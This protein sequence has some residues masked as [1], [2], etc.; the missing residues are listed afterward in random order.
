[1]LNEALKICVDHI[2]GIRNDPI[3]PQISY[4]ELSAI[5]PN[6]PPFEGKEIQEVINDV[7]DTILPYATKIGHPRFLAWII[8]SPSPAGTIGEMINTGL[9]QVPA[10]FKGGK[11]STI[12]EETV[13]RWFG[14][15]FGYDENHGGILVSGGTMANLTAMAAA[16]EAKYPGAMKTGIQN[17]E[18]PLT[19]Y[20]S[21][22]SHISVDRS[23]GML[24]IGADMVRK[25]STDDDYKMRLDLLEEAVFNDRSSGFEP[26]CV[27]AQAGAVNTGSIDPIDELADFCSKNGLWYHVDASY[28]GGAVLAENGKELLK[29]I[30]K[31]D[32]IATDPHKWFFIPVE[33]GLTLVKNRKHLFNAFN[34]KASY[35]G[36]ETAVDYKDYG[37]QLTRASRALK[38]WFS[39]RVYGL[40][41]LG[42][43]VNRNIY[44]AQKLH[45]MLDKE[46]CWEVL[47]PTE[48]SIVC[49]R[50]IPGNDIDEESLNSLQYEILSEVEKSGK[51]FITPAILRGKTALRICFANHRTTSEDV[52]IL[53]KIILDIGE[54]LSNR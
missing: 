51:A 54:K 30:E 41:R 52:D 9:N 31:A 47:A 42:E 13:T 20:V 10:L 28:G 33:A 38:I 18:K 22:Q 5:I 26:F 44:L 8:T 3:M 7:R 6:D 48:L 40:K 16:R 17:I 37:F 34:C 14:N 19:I 50:Y 43:I 4:E 21:D 12:L 32:S 1:Y 39:F 23:A 24:G 15:L 2:S 29:G 49:F 35:L 36:E 27:V 11:A 53:Y 45:S 46:E 25:I